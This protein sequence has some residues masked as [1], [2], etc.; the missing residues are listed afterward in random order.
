MVNEC[1]PFVRLFRRCG[2]GKMGD[3]GV[4]H[5]ETTAWEGE[6]AWRPR[7]EGGNQA[8]GGQTQVEE[9]GKAGGGGGWGWMWFK[10]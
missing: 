1:F 4:F 7:K 8:M 10:S 6:Y 3:G 9:G 5:V 2:E